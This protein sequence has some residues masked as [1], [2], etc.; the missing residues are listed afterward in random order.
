MVFP[1]LG[2]VQDWTLVGYGDAGV[3]SMPDKISSVGGKVIL[4]V[5]SKKEAACVLSWRSKKLNRKVVS[6][7]AGEALA[8]TATI[9]EIVYVKAILHQIYGDIINNIH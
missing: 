7:L 4:L 8:C 2:P 5:N 1:D 6:S 9:G 3:K